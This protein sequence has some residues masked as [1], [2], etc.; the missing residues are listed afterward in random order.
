MTASKLVNDVVVVGIE[1]HRTS[2]RAPGPFNTLR[3]VSNYPMTSG[4]Q[5][6]AALNEAATVSISPRIRLNE[7][8]SLEAHSA[9][10][11]AVVEVA[12]AVNR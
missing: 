6:R 7:S 3:G 1:G 10:A 2:T 5:P 12:L 4:H 8:R 11:S 9:E